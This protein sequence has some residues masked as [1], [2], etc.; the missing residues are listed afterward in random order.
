M[1]L[2]EK[3]RQMRTTLKPLLRQYAGARENLVKLH[4]QWHQLGPVLID[5]PS[6]L[7]SEEDTPDPADSEDMDTLLGED[8]HDAFMRGSNTGADTSPSPSLL[9]GQLVQAKRRRG[10]T[11]TPMAR[12]GPSCL[13]AVS[14]SQ[15]TTLE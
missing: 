7:L 11:R 5:A 3:I 14:A 2:K 10:H 6:P 13:M 9:M 1:G 12:A 8:D 4:A 15:A